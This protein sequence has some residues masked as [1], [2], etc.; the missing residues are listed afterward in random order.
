MIIVFLGDGGVGTFQSPESPPNWL[1]WTDVANEEYQ[2]FGDRGQQYRGELLRP[3][4][5]LS[6]EQWHLVETGVTDLAKVIALVDGA[7][8]VDEACSGFPDLESLRRHVI[9]QKDTQADN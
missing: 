7:H 1:E 9:A 2:F 8:Y 6:A 3:A 4:G 5:F